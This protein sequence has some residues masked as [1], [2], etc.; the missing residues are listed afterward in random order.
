MVICR[1]YMGG[2]RRPFGGLTLTVFNLIPWF[3]NRMGIL[4]F[5]YGHYRLWIADFAVCGCGLHN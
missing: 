3:T 4:W 2:N 1:G 5:L